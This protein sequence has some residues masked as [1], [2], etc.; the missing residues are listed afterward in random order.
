MSR[1][2]LPL[3]Y[4]ALAVGIFYGV[5]NPILLEV[6]EL[7]AEKAELAA[8]L[9]RAVELR[10]VAERLRGEYYSFTE[11]ERERLNRLIP[12][13]VDNVKLI[14]DINN[15]ATRYGMTIND[16]TI[17]TGAGPV[18]DGEDPNIR[19][20]N[21]PSGAISQGT[22]DIAFTVTG[23]YDVFRDFL[24][25]LAS[26]LRLVDVKAVSFKAVPEGDYQYSVKLTTYWL[27]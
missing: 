22:V 5:T 18:T 25:D 6:G 1:I 4:L 17:E 13:N 3:V 27:K 24:G 21:N 7:R 26:S 2:I 8:A 11:L 9:R 14:I 19:L 23:P 16:A 20:I 10:G 12:D 15:I